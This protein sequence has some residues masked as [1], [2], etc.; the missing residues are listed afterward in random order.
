MTCFQAS[1][2]VKRCQFDLLMLN[3][4]IVFRG[5][6]FLFWT[7]IVIKQWSLL[8][9]LSVTFQNRMDCKE[10]AIVRFI[11]DFEVPDDFVR[12]SSFEA[13]SWLFLIKF[14]NRHPLISFT[15]F[16]HI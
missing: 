8:K 16:P 10:G 5:S 7:L 11:A 2:D 1:F 15:R 12:L 9:G 6:E 4:M 14:K 13:F 3:F